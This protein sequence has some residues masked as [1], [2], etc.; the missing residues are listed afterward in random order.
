VIVRDGEEDIRM[1]DPMELLIFDIGDLEVLFKN[2]IGT[3][4]ETEAIAKPFHQ[5]VLRRVGQLRGDTLA[6]TGHV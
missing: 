4:E 3:T 6:R 1:Y 5:A 2:P